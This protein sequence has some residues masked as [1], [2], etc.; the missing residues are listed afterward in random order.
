LIAL[1]ESGAAAAS[2]QSIAALPPAEPLKS[3]QRSISCRNVPSGIDGVS[4]EIQPERCAIE[5]QLF[6][7]NLP[8]CS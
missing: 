8:P 4:T 7:T 5:A 2:R 3:S 1:D 6:L